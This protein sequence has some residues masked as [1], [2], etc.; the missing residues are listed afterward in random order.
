MSGLSSCGAF[1]LHAPPGYVPQSS[2]SVTAIIIITR[3]VI[4]VF[5][6][7]ILTRGG[8]SWAPGD[9]DGT[10]ALQASA[11]APDGSDVVMNRS[12]DHETVRVDAPQDPL[13]RGSIASSYLRPSPYSI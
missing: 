5:V 1:A 10:R 9:D 8:C 2:C 11:G 13:S 7:S 12:R 4:V 3:T 6:A